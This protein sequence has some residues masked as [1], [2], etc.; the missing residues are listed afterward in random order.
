MD[1]R[2]TFEMVCQEDTS[3]HL[4]PGAPHKMSETPVRIRRGPV[5]LGQDN[6]YVYQ[7][8]LGYTAQEYAVL[9]EEGHVGMDYHPGVKQGCRGIVAD[10]SGSAKVSH[11]PAKLGITLVAKS[12]NW[13]IITLWST[14]PVF[15]HRNSSRNC[16]S[17]CKPLICSVTCS[18]VP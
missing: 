18:G 4:C 9:K 17:L 2:G 15:S 16:N 10:Q 8:L 3:T 6:Q 5:R 13:R 1:Q 12:S 11:S 14:S 7:D